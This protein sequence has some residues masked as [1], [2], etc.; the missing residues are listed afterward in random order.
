M[1]KHP[2][3]GMTVAQHDA[4]LKAEGRYN[5]M[6]ES[7]SI[8]DA[9]MERR[10]TELHRA[11][12]PL[13][14]ELREGGF[15]G[16]SVWDLVNTRTPYPKLVPI[17]L[18]HLKVDYPE[19]VREGIARALAVPE[20]RSG[21]R[22]LVDEYLATP[23]M[24]DQGIKWALHLAIAATADASVLDELIKLAVDR[25]HGQDR[26][27]FVDALARMDD[28]RADAALAELANDPE[29]KDSFQRLRKVLSKRLRQ[30]PTGNPQ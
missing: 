11:Q 21:W 30:R 29:L 1:K 27:L 17:L 9:A 7:R 5:A 2:K 24:T 3:G 10:K 4:K 25:R 15:A 20:A 26:L 16:A 22:V 28:V 23:D 12:A 13:L 14:A 8:S 6:L 19:R 18:K